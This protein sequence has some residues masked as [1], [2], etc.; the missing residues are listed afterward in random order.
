ME[1]EQTSTSK[2]TQQYGVW[3]MSHTASGGQSEASVFKRTAPGRFSDLKYL[4][5]HEYITCLC[6]CHQTGC[7][8]FMV[9]VAT[10][11]GSAYRFILAIWSHRCT[12]MWCRFWCNLQ[13]SQ[14]T[15]SS[16]E[17][18][19]VCTEAT[20][21][22]RWTTSDCERAEGIIIYYYIIY[23]IEIIIWV[24]QVNMETSVFSFFVSVVI[25]KICPEF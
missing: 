13:E 11:D 6:H 5:C 8:L 24:S 17:L 15:C 18:I 9:L 7:C 21:R 16:C 10:N 20:Y 19:T 3:F 23:Y 22:P 12:H 2:H 1:P 4:F 25:C 14:T